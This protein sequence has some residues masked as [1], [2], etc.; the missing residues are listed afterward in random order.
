MR[1]RYSAYS[2]A[3]IDYIITTTHPGGP[4]Y[5]PDR[6]AWRRQLAVFSEETAFEGLEV[7]AREPGLIQSWVSFRATLRRGSQDISFAERSLFAVHEGRW[8]YHSG[9]P[10]RDS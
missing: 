4:Q 5:Q 10:I 6:A 8:L 1:S 3:L 2:L 7:L 9:E